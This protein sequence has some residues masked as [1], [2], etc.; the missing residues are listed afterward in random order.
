VQLISPSSRNLSGKPSASG[1]VR[2]A[3]SKRSRYN[4]NVFVR[5]CTLSAV[6]PTPLSKII[7]PLIGWTC[8][9]CSHV[10]YGFRAVN[11]QIMKMLISTFLY[12]HQDA[13]A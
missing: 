7:D 1:A 5:N 4:P 6:E 2:F 3:G 8:I 13:A 12:A 10:N 11:K 9:I